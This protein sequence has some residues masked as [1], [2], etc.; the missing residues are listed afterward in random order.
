MSCNIEAKQP[1]KF[2]VDRAN[3]GYMRECYIPAAYSNS[4]E[5]YYRTT[6]G[7]NLIAF[8]SARMPMTQAAAVKCSFYDDDENFNHWVGAA[9]FVRCLDKIEYAFYK[10]D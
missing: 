1:E 3:F 9:T 10:A 8:V 7:D 5:E 2:Y 4:I 6:L